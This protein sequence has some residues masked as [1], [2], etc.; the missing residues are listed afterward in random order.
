M[1]RNA[2]LVRQWEVLRAIDGARLGITVAKLAGERG[3]H[4]RTI[5]RDIDALCRAGF[6]LYDEKIN[7]T[8]MWKLRGRPFQSLDG[9]G[10]AA[11]ELAALCF[12]HAMLAA[13]AGAAFRTTGRTR[14]ACTAGSRSGSK[15]RS[16]PAPRTT[17]G[18]GS[19]TGPRQSRNAR[20]ARF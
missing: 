3:V 18:R 17:C 8:P 6:P 5:R 13:S 15:S 1:A 11:S 7:G 9:A 10:L 16:P 12:G 2:E 20:T 4:P 19:G 14:S